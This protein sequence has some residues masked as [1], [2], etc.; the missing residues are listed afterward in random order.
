MNT[1]L[2][3]LVLFFPAFL[4]KA[5]P[6]GFISA[7]VG[8]TFE[9]EG[10]FFELSGGL[11]EEGVVFAGGLVNINQSGEFLIGGELG[12]L[13]AVGV[14]YL[15]NITRARHIIRAY[16][17]YQNLFTTHWNFMVFPYWQYDFHEHSFGLSLKVPITINGEGFRLASK[18]DR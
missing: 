17:A 9:D 1:L 7:G 4:L 14:D 15:Y 16:P 2:F 8:M 5:S 11:S 3:V 6:T 13:P 12:A 18:I 10:L